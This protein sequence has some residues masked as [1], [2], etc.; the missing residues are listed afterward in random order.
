MTILYKKGIAER[1]FFFF[2]WNIEPVM[3]LETGSRILDQQFQFG[4]SPQTFPKKNNFVLVH[5]V[6]ALCILFNMRSSFF[7]FCFLLRCGTNWAKSIYIYIYQWYFH[8]L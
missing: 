2:D 3:K 6:R 7:L 1:T 5:Y 4:M 8:I